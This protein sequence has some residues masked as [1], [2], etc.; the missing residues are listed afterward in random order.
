MRGARALALSLALAALLAGPAGAWYK[1]AAGPN[2]YSVGRASG[3]LSGIRRSPYSRRAEPEPEPEPE[4]EAGPGPG[5]EGGPALL[6]PDLPGAAPRPPA[7]L[8]A[9]VS[10]RTGRA[11]AGGRL[12]A[13]GGSPRRRCA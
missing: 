2:Y 7:A 4:A 5:P 13:H 8:R 3:L 6:L 1:Q 11:A 10:A 12:R 9:M